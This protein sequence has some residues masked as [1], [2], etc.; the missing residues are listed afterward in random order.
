VS[1]ELDLDRRNNLLPSHPRHP[2]KV[3]ALAEQWG[4]GSPAE[5]LTTALAALGAR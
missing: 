5:R 3:A 2:D 1:R 4:L